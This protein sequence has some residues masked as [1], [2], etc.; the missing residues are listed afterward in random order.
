MEG[1]RGGGATC[2][3]V[4]PLKMINVGATHLHVSCCGHTHTHTPRHEKGAF[5]LEQPREGIRSTG[6]KGDNNKEIGL[7]RLFSAEILQR[8]A[9]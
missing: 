5:N 6:E 1:Q 4:S 9:G 3:V 7:T 8:N 2:R